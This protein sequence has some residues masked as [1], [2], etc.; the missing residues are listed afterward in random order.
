M[1][2]S[3]PATT[4]LHSSLSIV[5]NYYSVRSSRGIKIIRGF[6]NSHVNYIVTKNNKIGDCKTYPGKCGK[7]VINPCALYSRQ[8]QKIFPT[9]KDKGKVK[10]TKIFK[11]IKHIKEL[12]SQ[13]RKSHQKIKSSKMFKSNFFITF[14]RFF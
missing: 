14:K 13:W 6:S 8:V 9:H 3:P 2:A 5:S 7:D 11:I 12:Y 10:C 4:F 1:Q